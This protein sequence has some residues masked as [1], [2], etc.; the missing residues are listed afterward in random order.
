[1]DNLEDLGMRAARIARA[2][3]NARGGEGWQTNGREK[4]GIP[5]EEYD[6]PD[7]RAQHRSS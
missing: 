1:M 7:S 3:S 2:L 4:P 6:I 5:H